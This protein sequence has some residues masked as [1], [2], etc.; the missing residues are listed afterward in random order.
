MHGVQLW[1]A[2]PEES[3]LAAPAFEHHGELPGTRIGGLD[4]TVFLGALAGAQSPASVF[5]QIVGAE[6]AAAADGEALVPLAPT[7]EHVIFVATGAVHA[8]GT[9]LA[10]SSLLYLPPGLERLALSC[11]AGTRMFLLGG[12]PLGEPLLMWWNFVARTPAEFAAATA[13]WRE[14]RFGTVGGY[15]GEPMAAPLLDAARL[16]APRPGLEYHAAGPLGPTMAA[17]PAA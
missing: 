2:L 7:F 12:V 15:D 3:R 13:S 17:R 4:I 1:V 5:S 14:G 16:R 10:P 11:R 8:S 6:L 9:E